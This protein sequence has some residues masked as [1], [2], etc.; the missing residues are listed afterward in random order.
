MIPIS[1]T[2]NGLNIQYVPSFFKKEE[3]DTYL[4]QLRILP[5][6]TSRLPN[7]L[8]LAYGEPDL[9]YDFDG[10]VPEPWTPLMLK[11]RDE[12]EKFTF[13]SFNFV[14]LNLYP[15]GSSAIPH[16]KDKEPATP[17]ATAVLSFGAERTIEFKKP[18]SPSTFIKV[19]HGS[20]Y[21]IEQPSHRL[22]TYAFASEPDVKTARIS[23]T[24]Y[25]LIPN[26]KKAR[27]D[28]SSEKDCDIEQLSQNDWLSQTFQKA[29]AITPILNE[30]NLNSNIFLQIVMNSNFNL[31][32]HIRMFNE[33]KRPT[34][35]GVMMTELTWID[36]QSKISKINFRSCSESI[37]ANNQLIC[38]CID[39]DTV[40]L[41][42]MFAL[43]THGFFLK[44]TVLK[45]CR[46]QIFEIA[47]LRYE[48]NES[49]IE[50]ML[51]VQLPKLIMSKPAICNS[52]LSLEESEKNFYNSVC[53]E[54]IAC[55]YD[56]IECDAC[57][58]MPSNQDLHIC[59]RPIFERYSLDPQNVLLQIN[60]KKIV[61]NIL[62]KCTCHLDALFFNQLNF[63][64]FLNRIEDMLYQNAL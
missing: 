55:V 32:V 62:Q 17:F 5:F 33:L 8:V 26:P 61:E 2:Q 4:N 11:L 6:Y 64:I 22:F 47:H 45:L 28:I 53:S 14:L 60:V 29:E 16:C 56:V 39:K 48:I 40:I 30:W 23:L 24:F 18:D 9:S 3:A 12:V 58:V 43:N 59:T 27:M 41:Q 38:V 49:L 44:P 63:K 46:A 13:C 20:L 15:D 51:M 36:L 21:S 54:I 57:R 34:K 50:A 31:R 35:I 42:Q 10:I 7:L 19:E 37:I 25:H 1:Y 52:H